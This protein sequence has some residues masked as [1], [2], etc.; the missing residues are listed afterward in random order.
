MIPC[1]IEDEGIK[2][3]TTVAASFLVKSAMK[4]LSDKWL[5]PFGSFLN[6]QWGNSRR[7]VEAGWFRVRIHGEGIEQ[8]TSLKPLGSRQDPRRRQQVSNGWASDRVAH[9]AV[10]IFTR[11]TAHGAS[12]A[13]KHGAVHGLLRFHQLTR[14]P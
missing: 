8:T 10:W 4:E 2:S 11:G 5:K 9:G 14:P 3:E 7:K 6:L 1:E 13:S 12:H